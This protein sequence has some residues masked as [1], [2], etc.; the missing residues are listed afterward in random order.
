VRL[1][2]LGHACWLLEASGL[3]VALDP[4]LFE[5]HAGDVFEVVPRRRVDVRTLR[6]DFI[7]VSHAHFDHF[8]VRSLHALAQA[9]PDTVLV[10]SDDLVERAALALGFRTVHKIPPATRIELSGGLSFAT[11]PSYAP[12]VEW[13]EMFADASGVV[14]NM[15]DTVFPST[16]EVEQIR[17]AAAGGR[18]IDLVLAPIQTLREIAMSTADDVGFRADDHGHLLAV[19]AA[20]G[21]KVV[22]PSACGEA[23]AP[24][25]EAMNRFV[26]PV[27]RRRA[28]RDLERYAPGI[29]TV[30]PELGQALVVEAGQVTVEP[31]SIGLE[32]L[33][34][35]ADPRSFA[36]IEGAPMF[37]PNLEGRAE[38]ELADVALAWC[39]ST[40][41]PALARAFEHRGDLEGTAYVLEIVL[42]SDRLHVRFDE[43]GVMS[44]GADPE[45]DVLVSVAGSML[46]DVIEGRR[47]WVEPLLAGLLRSSV[48][49]A[50]VT[51]GSSRLLNVAPIFPYY[52]LPYRDS[53]ERAVL[54]RVEALVGARP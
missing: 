29:R 10:T 47:G 54:R 2:H 39:A 31:G 33:S 35:G 16:R 6:A 24:P 50:H 21:A 1:N 40:L 41:G 53:I 45:Y 34:D 17:D 30:V 14:W 12:D 19:A 5:R 44:R 18:P 38:G 9:D 49:A 4:L 13:G 32:R 28:A 46:A 42:P 36:P 25:Y 15:I 26:Y 37:D 48:R 52:A 8:D 22:A 27:S 11:T 43:R 20:A 51:P 23:F 7:L 3:R